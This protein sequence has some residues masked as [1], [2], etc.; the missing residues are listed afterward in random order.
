[1]TGTKTVTRRRGWWFLR[2]GDV[3]CAIE[4]GMGLKR[5]EKIKRIGT[6]QILSTRAEPLCAIT[7]EDCVLEGF[8]EMQPIDFIL[9]F[10]GEMGGPEDQ[11]VN[12]IE[13]R[14]LKHYEE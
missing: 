11:E 14:W 3:V 8:P 5:G 10:A 4:K 2:P 12:R 6:I 1:M 13:F 9:F 7:P